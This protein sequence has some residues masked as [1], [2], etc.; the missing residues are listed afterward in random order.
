MSLGKAAWTEVVSISSDMWGHHGSAEWTANPR[1]G[2]KFG[3][4]NGAL[5]G[6]GD[7][8]T[9]KPSGGTVR[10]VKVAFE[11]ILRDIF[12]RHIRAGRLVEA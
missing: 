12:R 3:N 10:S 11:F 9:G 7:P 5:F 6:R 4:R 1:V 8:G 2:L